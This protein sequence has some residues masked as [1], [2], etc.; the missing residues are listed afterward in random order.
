MASLDD[1]SVD[2]FAAGSSPTTRDDATV[3]R[4]AGEHGVAD[5]VA[6][7]VE[8]RTL[9]VPD[10]DHAVVSG[11]GER[12]RQLAAHHRGCR[13]LLVHSGLHHDRQ[14]GHR[15]AARRS[16]SVKVPTGEP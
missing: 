11:V 1:G 4:R 6:A 2:D 8:A 14:V 15:A 16:S 12:H 10:A 7:A 13:Q 3:R 5:R 9:A